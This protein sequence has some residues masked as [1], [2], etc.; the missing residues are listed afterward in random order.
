MSLNTTYTETELLTQLKEGNQA[1]FTAIYNRYW[2]R[3]F[4][5]AHK[6]LSSSEDA[7]EIVQ[8][9][10]FSLWQKRDRLRI[11]NLEL[12]LGAMTRY[13]VYRHLANKKRMAGLLDKVSKENQQAEIIDIDNKQ[14]LEILVNLSNELPRNYRIVFIQYKLQDRPLA[15]VAEELGVSVRTAERY[16]DKLMGAMREFRSKLASF[17]LF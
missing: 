10:F 14:F 7:K 16:V 2:E 8:N 6:R 5:M 9:I 11:E 3:L 13:A 12:Y 1:A 4:F 15:E 17:L